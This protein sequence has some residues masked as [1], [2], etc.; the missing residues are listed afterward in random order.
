MWLIL[1]QDSPADYVIS[2]GIGTS[3]EQFLNYCFSYVNLD[4][5]NHVQIDPKY[6]RP[7]E[8]NSLIGDS[9]KARKQL[10]WNSSVDAEKLAEIM[11]VQELKKYHDKKYI[12]NFN[13]RY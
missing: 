7:L 12:D 2:T 3:V 9:S 8:V 4:W 1:Q 10:G 5:K 13:W 11:M 6:F